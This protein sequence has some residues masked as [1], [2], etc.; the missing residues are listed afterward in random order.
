MNNV[1]EYKGYHSKIEFD[2]KDMI[3]YGKVEGIGD[4]VSFQSDSI[5]QI[6]T[7]FHNAVDDYFDFCEEVGKIIEFNL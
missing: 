3:L 6:E 7:E 1:L 4:F 2:S 5:E